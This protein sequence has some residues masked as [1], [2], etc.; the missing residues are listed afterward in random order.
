MIMKAIDIMLKSYTSNA[1]TPHTVI[2]VVKIGQVMHEY[3]WPINKQ[4]G[5]LI[6]NKI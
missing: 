1:N 3:Y 4:W 5:Q 2:N 6:I